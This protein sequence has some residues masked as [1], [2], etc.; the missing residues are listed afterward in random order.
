MVIAMAI[1]GVMQMPADKIVQMVAV[2]HLLTR[3]DSAIAARTPPG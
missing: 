2:R 1:V 3:T